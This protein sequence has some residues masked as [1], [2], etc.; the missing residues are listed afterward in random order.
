VRGAVVNVE[1]FRDVKPILDRSC[2]ACHTQKW[3]KPAGKL[4]LDD[5]RSE[6]HADS[7]FPHAKLPK[8]SVSE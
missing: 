6:T 5:D 7:H 8:N 1:Y 3:E 2:V 4:V